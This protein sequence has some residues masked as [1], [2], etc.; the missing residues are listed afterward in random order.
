MSESTKGSIEVNLHH[1]SHEPDGKTITTHVNAVGLLI[2]AELLANEA[3]AVMDTLLKQST[4]E[5]KE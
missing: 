1:E 4:K 3:K 5:D 2:D